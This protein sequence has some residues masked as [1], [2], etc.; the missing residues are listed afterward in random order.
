[1]H[2]DKI[3]IGGKMKRK[4][5]YL[6]AIPYAVLISSLTFIGLFL[7]FTVGKRFDGDVFLFAFSAFLTF[8][9]FAA[10]LALSYFILKSKYFDDAGGAGG[11]QGGNER[12]RCR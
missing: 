8:A 6:H 2:K 5:I 3:N 11:K 1:M 4:T 9:G 10:G 12:E 7:G